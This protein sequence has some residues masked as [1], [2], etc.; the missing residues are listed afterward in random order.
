M[1]A[2][3][4]RSTR[5]KRAASVSSE[6]L[7][8]KKARKSSESAKVANWRDA[9]IDNW[10]TLVPTDKEWKRMKA[11]K[12][13]KIT[14]PTPTED[15]KADDAKSHVSDGGA[16]DS[17]SRES[18][19]RDDDKLT[20]VSSTNQDAPAEETPA[21]PTAIVPSDDDK[22]D[23][24][25][26]EDPEDESY[27]V[28]GIEDSIL[29]RSA[30]ERTDDTIDWVGE[31]REIKARK[32]EPSEVYLNIKWYHNVS[33]LKLITKDKNVLTNTTEEEVVESDLCSK[34]HWSVID[35]TCNV[36]PFDE[37]NPKTE[38]IEPGDFFFRYKTSD[39]NKRLAKRPSHFLPE[40]LPRAMLQPELALREVIG[41]YVFRKTKP[42]DRVGIPPALFLLAGSPAVRGGKYGVTGNIQAVGRARALVWKKITAGEAIPDTWMEDLYLDEVTCSLY[43]ALTPQSEHF[44]CPTCHTPL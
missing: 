34:I 13:F 40:I 3:P 26:V 5:S 20:A 22:R 33:E 41:A 39:D 7:P 43:S 28:V 19:E 38:R 6:D 42:E 1:S 32:N 4:S 44:E 16:D 14:C 35:D 21:V 25:E 31:V 36:I 18:E 10:G 15:K 2:V 17:S 27:I 24:K 30:A 29:V 37:T 11:Y 9:I 12:W 8:L 23:R